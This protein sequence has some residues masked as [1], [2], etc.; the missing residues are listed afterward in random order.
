VIFQSH[1]GRW[2]D[3]V[4]E[5]SVA[6]EVIADNVDQLGGWRDQ[7]TGTGERFAVRDRQQE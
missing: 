3:R 1:S 6:D 7:H 4:A 2:C 5:R